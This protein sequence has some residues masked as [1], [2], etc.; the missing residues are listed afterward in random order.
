MTQSAGERLGQIRALKRFMQ[1]LLDADGG[2]SLRQ[3]RTPVAAHENDWNIRP[4]KSDLASEL[5]AH[6]LGHRLIGKNQS[7]R[8]GLD[9]NTCSASRLDLNPTGS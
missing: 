1:H 2:R 7:K 8:S 6:D 4:Q 5:G 3:G 9:R